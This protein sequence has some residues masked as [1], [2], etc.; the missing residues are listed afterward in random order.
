MI[1]HP[2]LDFVC[3]A[4][5]LKNAPL[6]S[7]PD[8]TVDIN[9]ASKVYFNVGSNVGSKVGSIFDSIFELIGYQSVNK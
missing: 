2:L 7:R 5:D 3:A 9:L 8:S 6:E 4:E 1:L